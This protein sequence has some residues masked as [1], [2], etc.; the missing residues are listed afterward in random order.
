MAKQPRPGHVKTRL[1][2]EPAAAADLGLAFLDD[3]VATAGAQPGAGLIIAADP[4]A[5]T[6]WFGTRFPAADYVLPQ[7]SGSLSNRMSD[8]FAQGFRLGYRPVVMIGAD[9]PDMPAQRLADA[10]NELASRDVVF[11]P[12][13]DGGYFLIGLRAPARGLFEGLR[14]S[15]STALH[16]AERAARRMGLSVGQIEPWPDVD[17]PDDLDALAVRI[18]AGSHAPATLAALERVRGQ[19]PVAGRHSGELDPTVA[20]P[21]G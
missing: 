16:D 4:P 6:K 15:T 12:A 5:A 7:T 1:G 21:D 20:K 2:L 9:V 19:S 3:T 11:G 17:T 13:H 8:A 18:A 14:T 10:L